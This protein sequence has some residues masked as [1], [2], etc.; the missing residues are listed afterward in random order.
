M[1]I[2]CAHSKKTAAKGADGLM[3]C[4]RCKSTNYCSRE[5]QK[6]DWKQH[7][8]FCSHQ[9]PLSRGVG[10]ALR[11]HGKAAGNRTQ[12]ERESA[13][14]ERMAG[15]YQMAQL[16]PDEEREGVNAPNPL[17]TATYEDVSHF[18]PAKVLE[19]LE[20]IGFLQVFHEIP[21]VRAALDESAL[22]G[23]GLL[24][25]ARNPVDLERCLPFGPA[26]HLSRIVRELREAHGR[27]PTCQYNESMLTSTQ[28]LPSWWD[29]RELPASMEW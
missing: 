20:C 17:A 16:L 27:V 18:T 12:P 6:V 26:R 8:K 13:P 29:L 10:M 28:R 19:W 2:V 3:L 11:I 22:S 1:L 25:S 23:S 5:C 24:E 9:E 4:G 21:A 7:K 14:E 15:S